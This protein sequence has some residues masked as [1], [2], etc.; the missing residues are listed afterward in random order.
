MV[1]ILYIKH[2]S[3]YQN[4]AYS[5]HLFYF[6]LHIYTYKLRKYNFVTYRN[7]VSAYG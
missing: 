6:N 1:T 7:I 3:L 5:S 4:F 2:N